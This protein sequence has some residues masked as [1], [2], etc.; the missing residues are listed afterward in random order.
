MRKSA[1]SEPLIGH[2]AFVVWKVMVKKN[3]NLVNI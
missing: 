3:I 1:S 2:A